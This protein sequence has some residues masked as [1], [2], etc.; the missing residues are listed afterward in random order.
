MFI[1]A[2]VQRFLTDGARPPGGGVRTLSRG[3]ASRLQDGREKIIKIPKI[4]PHVEMQVVGL[5]KHTN[6]SSFWQLFFCQKRL[7]TNLSFTGVI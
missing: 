3:G 1:N 6:K 2:L 5:L 7:Q 4:P